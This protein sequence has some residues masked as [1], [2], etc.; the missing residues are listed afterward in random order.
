MVV[1][2]PEQLVE[3][4]NRLKWTQSF[5][6]LLIYPLAPCPLY[7]LTKEVGVY[8]ITLDFYQGLD[9]AFSLQIKRE[10]E[11]KKK[12][13]KKRK[14]KVEEKHFFLILNEIN[15]FVLLIFYSDNNYPLKYK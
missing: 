14:K 11:K 1:F 13:E 5:R 6:K 7:S 2:G 8:S 9:V 4:P 12:E 3:S 10:R 15:V